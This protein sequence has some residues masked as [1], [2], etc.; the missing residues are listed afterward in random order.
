MKIDGD[1]L[2]E[3]LG[4]EFKKHKSKDAGRFTDDFDLIWARAYDSG[5]RTR[6]SETI[7]KIKELS[8]EKSD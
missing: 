6:I 2:I 5:H 7:E 1:K 8:N 3:W 4:N